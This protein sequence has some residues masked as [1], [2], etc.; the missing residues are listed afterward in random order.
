VPYPA[1]EPCRVEAS[2]PVVGEAACRV[3]VEPYRVVV[4]P[5]YRAAEPCR[6]GLSF[7]A[8]AVEAVDLHWEEDS[9][10]FEIERERDF[11]GTRK[12]SSLFL[13]MVLYCTCTVVATQPT[14]HSSSRGRY[15]QE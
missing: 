11:G 13:S 5:P 9:T 10:C 15:K 7:P 14:K 2:Y 1:V 3:V 8:A 6:V 12:L 4:E